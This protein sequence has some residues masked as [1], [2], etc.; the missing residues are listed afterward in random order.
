MD[1]NILPGHANTQKSTLE[2][3]ISGEIAADVPLLNLAAV[4]PLSRIEYGWASVGLTGGAEW[5]VGFGPKS[6]E[7]VSGESGHHE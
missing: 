2:R 1:G 3:V 7:G 5:D 4:E 6:G